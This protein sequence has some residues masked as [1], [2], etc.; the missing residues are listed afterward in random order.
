[1]SHHPLGFL[2][3]CFRR[4]FRVLHSA[5]FNPASPFGLR[6]DRSA[7]F[8]LSLALALCLAGPAQANLVTGVTANA[9][10]EY[11][12][13]WPGLAVQAVNGAGMSDTGVFN[14]TTKR[15]EFNDG[16]GIHTVNYSIDPS[17]PTH[18][19]GDED[20]LWQTDYKKAPGWFIATFPSAR[21]VSEFAVWNY[22]GIWGGTSYG[23]SH[24]VKTL[25]IETYT[26]GTWNGSDW[27]GGAWGAQQVVPMGYTG[28]G[29]TTWTFAQAPGVD[30]Y[31]GQGFT[32]SSAWTGVQ[33]VRL[34][35]LTDY[36]SPRGYMGLSEVRF[37]S[38]TLG[39]LGL[40]IPVSDTIIAGGEGAVGATVGN[41]A[42]DGGGMAYTLTGAF[43][44]GSGTVTSSASGT[45]AP[46]ASEA[47]TI[48]VTSTTP[49]LNT[50]TLTAASAVAD[51]SPKTIDTT[52]TVLA[53]SDAR[54]QTGTGG[55]E[56][57]LSDLD[58]ALEID[59]GSVAPGAGGG[60]LTADFS[61]LNYE[62]VSGYTAALDL[63]T[64]AFGVGD[65]MTLF[66]M[67]LFDPDGGLFTNMAAGGAKPYTILFDTSTEGTFSATYTF[68]FSDQDGLSGSSSVGSTTLTV[69]GTVT[70]EPA[71]LSLL[72][73][74]GLGLLLRRKRK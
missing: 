32:L 34:N 62:T 41:I 59:F 6:R 37:Y 30:A 27:T 71:T 52:L 54:F 35:I 15:W 14:T 2:R 9:Y 68:Y 67:E 53:H 36:G 22:N 23:T 51:N 65:W 3:G 17:R 40:S 8:I 44:V 29:T 49:G 55:V 57:T 70:P 28:E 72:A 46:L 61:V 64:L 42:S 12:Y 31:T 7:I 47:K 18:Q 69:M 21:T 26:G 25:N 4:S 11:N 16:S 63:D 1:M 20:V 73:L 60:T 19:T 50:V 58:N 43:T 56:Q 38:P 66:L 48:Q 39:T 33:K 45:L 5:I 10:S 13:W 74:G 24:G